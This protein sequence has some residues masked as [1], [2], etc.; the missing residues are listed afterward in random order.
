[1]LEEYVAGQRF[2]ADRPEA[3][4]NLGSLYLLRGDAVGAE[5]AYRKAQAID[6]AFVP[7]WVNLADLQR[8]Q[9]DEEA[10]RQTLLAG[11]KVVPGDA[12]LRHA[13]GLSYARTGDLEA[14]VEELEA[15]ATAAPESARYTFVY[16]IALHSAGREQ[17]SIRALEQGLERHPANREYLLTLASIHLDAGR[18]DDALQY[19]AQAAQAYPGDPEVARMLQ[20]LRGQ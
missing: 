1:V 4:V 8:A 12:T 15:A 20:S 5:A 2:N 14:A 16:A 7:A 18:R 6:P 17:E 3:H 9:A 13:L 10:S 11:L 19:L